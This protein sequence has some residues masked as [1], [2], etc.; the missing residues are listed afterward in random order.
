MINWNDVQVGKEM[1][2]ERYQVVIDARRAAR[3]RADGVTL[4]GRVAQW[5]GEQLVAL[6]CRLQRHSTASTPQPLCTDAA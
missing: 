5:L 2:Q 1:A 3:G 4:P 6:G